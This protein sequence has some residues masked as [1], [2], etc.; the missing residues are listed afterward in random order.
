MGKRVGAL[1][2][3][4]AV[5]DGWGALIGRFRRQYGADLR[6]LLV[7]LPWQDLAI[8][9]DELDSA[10]SDTDE[11][12]ARLVDLINY[13]VECEHVRST[14]SPAEA[15]RAQRELAGRAAPPVPIIRPVARRPAA[16]HARLMV[17]YE[18]L[19][20]RHEGA[21]ETPAGQMD[22]RALLSLLHLDRSDLVVV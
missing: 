4:D 10:W 15:R 9:V 20:A 6:E 2:C 3:L 19:M 14:T 8:L 13:Q 21:V 7:S 11:N 16:V 22:P 5:R 12:T 1:T 18:E 17:Q